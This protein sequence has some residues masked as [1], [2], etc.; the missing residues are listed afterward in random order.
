MRE[1]SWAEAFIGDISSPKVLA[2]I[3]ADSKAER[4][5]EK[6]KSLGKFGSKTM[7][8]K[9]KVTI[10]AHTGWSKPPKNGGEYP[11]RFVVLK[12]AAKSPV[13]GQYSVHTQVNDFVHKDYFIS[14]HYDM[15]MKPASSLL[16]QVL[17]RNNKDFPKGNMSYVDPA[18]T[19]VGS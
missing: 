1:K 6:S 2:E 13:H 18:I 17:A 12:W 10:V 14:G 11:V 5:K 15:Q 7:T 3:L 8:E 9:P 4:A 16:K 19:I